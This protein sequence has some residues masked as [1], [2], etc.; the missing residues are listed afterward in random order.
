V[1]G[2]GEVERL[3]VRARVRERL[4]RA[5][6]VKREGEGDEACGGRGSRAVA[7]WSRRRAGEGRG[8]SQMEQARL[9][10]LMRLNVER[11]E[12]VV[13]AC[14]AAARV[15][16]LRSAREAR[17][18]RSYAVD[19]GIELWAADWRPDLRSTHA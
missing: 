1:K 16:R 8:L 14:G 7:G 9:H 10:G 18:D 11:T 12:R 4:V 19:D 5:I 15:A 17:V 2:L 6:A 13:G 3:R